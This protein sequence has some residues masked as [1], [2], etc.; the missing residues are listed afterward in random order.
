MPFDPNRN[1]ATA[2]CPGCGSPMAFE[3]GEL[4]D[5]IRPAV[6]CG[7]CGRVSP[8]HRLAV[9]RITRRRPSDGDVRSRS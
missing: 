3:R 9:T 7:Y 5:R 4:R 8:R 1:T 6:A 2:P